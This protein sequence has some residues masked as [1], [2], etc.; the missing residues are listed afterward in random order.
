[1]IRTKNILVAAQVAAENPGWT[2]G[3]CVHDGQHYAGEPEQLANIGATIDDDFVT[4]PRAGRK[5][6]RLV[7]RFNADRQRQTMLLSGLDLAAA[8]GNLFQTDGEPTP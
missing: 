4:D 2:I 6:A 3:F 5:T 1:M 7:G 8:Q